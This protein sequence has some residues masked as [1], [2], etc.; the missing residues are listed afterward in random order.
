MTYGVTTNGGM[1]AE[2]FSKCFTRNFIQNIPPETTA[3]LIY[4]G[5]SSH[6]GVVLVEKARKWN[7]AILKLP[8]HTMFPSQWILVFLDFRAKVG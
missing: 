3:V 8:P 5:H 4:D 2:T 7:I 1:A 6:I